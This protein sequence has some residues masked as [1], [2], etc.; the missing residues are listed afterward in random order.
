MNPH[1]NFFSSLGRLEKRLKLETQSPQQHQQETT[2]ISPNQIERD[3]P[4]SLG[5]PVYLYH[6]NPI[7]TYNPS[8]NLQESEPPQAFFSNSIPFSPIQDN[9]NSK[10][11]QKDKEIGDANVNEIEM[12]MQLLGLDNEEQKSGNLSAF[13]GK[14]EIFF[15][16]IVG[17]KGPKSGRQLERLNGWIKYL[18]NK[19]GDGGI[20]Q[21]LRLA[22][23]LLAKASLVHFDDDDDFE[24][25]Q[26]PPTVEEF[27]QYDP[28]VN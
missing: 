3:Q 9:P 26:F 1:S 28:P 2:P 4:E 11:S 8:S 24:R 5:S 18:L 15:G 12:L 23:L 13:E 20:K 27:L 21:P 19:D 14:D 17:V 10:N 22:H 25:P 7:S 16:K 6:S